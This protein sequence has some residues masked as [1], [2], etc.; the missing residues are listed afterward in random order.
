VAAERSGPDKRTAVAFAAAIG[1]VAGL[2]LTSH[3][4]ARQAALAAAV[5][6]AALGGSEAVARARQR[7]NEIPPLWQRIATSVALAAPVGWAA[8]RVPRASPRTVGTAVGGVAGLLGVRP[9]KVALG[10]LVGLAVGHALTPRR[11]PGSVVAAGTVLAF[12]VLSAAVFR[13]AQVSLLAERVRAE[14]L[15]FV[16]PRESRSRYEGT[17][18]VREL[19]AALGGT[20]RADAPDVGIIASL[21]DLAGPDLDPAQVDPLVREFYEHTTRF[22][23]DIVPEWRPGRWWPGR[24]ARPACR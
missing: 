19:A 4:G 2:T 9:Q 17:G 23:L 20:Y 5:G 6:A 3:R 7:P 1:A 15:P 14:D 13:D 11:P 16:V 22:T 12:R 21:G 18:Y 24:W 8:E 10:P